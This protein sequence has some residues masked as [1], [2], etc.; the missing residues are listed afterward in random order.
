[1][2]GVG[3]RVGAPVGN[4]EVFLESFSVDSALGWAGRFFLRTP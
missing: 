4:L 2:L 3:P 1:M